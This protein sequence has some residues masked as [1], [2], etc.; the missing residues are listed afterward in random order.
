MKVVKA[1]QTLLEGFEAEQLGV[2]LAKRY[3][4]FFERRELNLTAHALNKSTDQVLSDRAAF[5][6]ADRRA[7]K[8]QKRQANID[9]AAQGIEGLLKSTMDPN[10]VPAKSMCSRHCQKQGVDVQGRSNCPYC[11][12]QGFFAARKMKEGK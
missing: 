10:G 4:S 2:A 3:P 7:W 8:N 1:N 11:L 5:G 6:A 12:G 9:P